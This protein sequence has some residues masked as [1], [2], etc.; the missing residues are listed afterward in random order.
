MD[1]SPGREP[2]SPQAVRSTLQPHTNIQI[3]KY[4]HTQ[5]P[6]YHSFCAVILTCWCKR[7]TFNSLVSSQCESRVPKPCTKVLCTKHQSDDYQA[8]SVMY[9]RSRVDPGV[10]N[11]QWQT[12]AA[13]QSPQFPL[14][15]HNADIH[16][17]FNLIRQR[18]LILLLILL[19]LL[20]LS[21]QAT[22]HNAPAVN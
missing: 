18:L 14:A 11:I 6:N 9:F 7:I 15:S 22:M 20:I 3:H 4:I 13:S 12:S 19:I 17:L 8:P 5:A 2:S 10:G 21:W 16:H 1:Q